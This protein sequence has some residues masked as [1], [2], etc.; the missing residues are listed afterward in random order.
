[1]ATMDKSPAGP[2][3]CTVCTGR[4]AM[5]HFVHRKRWFDTKRSAIADR[6]HICFSIVAAII[7]AYPA[8]Y[9]SFHQTNSSEAYNSNFVDGPNLLR[10]C[11]N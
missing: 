4:T 10:Q 5:A 1:M 2:N 7:L 11:G 6:R 3:L 8:A 9:A